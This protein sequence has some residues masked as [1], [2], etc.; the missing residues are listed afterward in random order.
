M[1]FVRT[2][3]IMFFTQLSLPVIAGAATCAVLL[4]LTY[5]LYFAPLS[6][7][8]GPKWTAATRLW[9][10]YH[11]FMG[12]R[13][14]VLDKLH[15]KYGP[16]VRVAPD[17][18]SFNDEE[19]L[20]EIYGIKSG[21]GKSDF[22]DMFVYYDERNTFTSPTKTEHSSRKRLVADNYT[23]S[24]VMQ[25]SVAEMIKGHVA[26][27]MTV[28]QQ[29]PSVDVYQ[30]L[31]YYAMDV[32]TNH[33]YGAA[34]TNTIQEPTHRSLVYDLAGQK[35]RTRLYLVYYF[36]LV[37]KALAFFQSLARKLKGKTSEFHVRGGDLNDYGIESVLKCRSDTGADK[38][39][40]TT[41]CEK[42]LRKVPDNNK[43][44]AAEC[45]DHL[46]AGVD[47]TG[48]AMCVLM[49]KMSTPECRHVQ[50]KLF[51]ELS[52]ISHAFDPHTMTAPIADLDNLPYL[53]AVIKEGLRWRPPVPMTL[54]RTVPKGES[55]DIS[56]WT[57]PSGTVVGSQAYS[58]HRNPK[59][60]DNPDVFDPDRWFTE[61]QEKSRAMK[62]HYW[63]FS[64]G[65]RHCLGHN[66]ATV[67]MKM[68]IA[69][70][71]MYY[72]TSPGAG[73]TEESMAMD[74]QLTSGVPYGLRCV[75]DFKRRQ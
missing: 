6:K 24:Y 25:P 68:L 26:A 47:T 71:Y 54:F 13:T 14:V 56:G 72:T 74:D 20:R 11:E 2:Q 31:H 22:Y 51:E 19:A 5:R 7:F 52:T 41:T 4:L 53:E 17:E 40:A 67:E 45:M 15:A 58:L 61:D 23:K 27:L 3:S 28:I 46:V 16:V 48:D 59:V 30:Y 39:A 62:A 55:K 63:P 1:R 75:L 36:G 10:M 57:I 21:C 8:P 73:C 50:D 66:I 70:V 44:V 34:G 35:H 38:P 65:A 9:I 69:A 49:W 43:Q 42:M 12:Q 60:F 32:I 64:S 33:V 37:M 29:N 18:V